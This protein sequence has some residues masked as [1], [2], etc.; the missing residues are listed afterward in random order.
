MDEPSG[1]DPIIYFTL[2]DFLIQIIF[3]VVFAFVVFQALDQHRKDQ[4]R[5]EREKLKQMAELPGWVRDPVYLP[6]LRD[7][8]PFITIKNE[9]KL[10][11]L[12]EML[13]KQGALEQFLKFLKETREPF[14]LIEQC[15]NHPDACERFGSL[16]PS[17][18][19]KFMKGVGLPPC[20]R[21]MDRLFEADVFDDR[22]EVRSVS[23]VGRKVLGENQVQLTVGDV[24]L[25]PEIRLRLAGLKKPDCMHYF[26]YIKKGDSEDMRHTIEQVLR[27]AIVR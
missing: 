7:M 14:A 25:K 18:V 9:R 15:L 21:T 10:R 27:P 3:C 22:L 2:I 24:I 19:G 8:T 23:L 20:L 17:E 6:L 26:S 5:S 11:E 13:K 12:L 1:N 16:T 4:E